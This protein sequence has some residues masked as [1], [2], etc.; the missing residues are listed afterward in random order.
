MI[1]SFIH[2]IFRLLSSLVDKFY[3]TVEPC[4]LTIAVQVPT[5]MH[6]VLHFYI[7]VLII[8]KSTK[9]QKLMNKHND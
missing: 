9:I 4:S 3:V 7:I 5:Y 1:V 6:I 2:L 8:Y